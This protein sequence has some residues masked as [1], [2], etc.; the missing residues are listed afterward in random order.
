MTLY[1]SPRHVPAKIPSYMSIPWFLY[2]S[3]KI[4]YNR[5]AVLL[6]NESS[7]ACSPNHLHKLFTNGTIDLLQAVRIDNHEYSQV[8]PS[9]CS[10]G[11][12]NETGN[13]GGPFEIARTAESDESKGSFSV[14]RGINLR[15]D[16]EQIFPGM[17]IVLLSAKPSF[18]SV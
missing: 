17:C 16:T 9:Q 13:I 3:N 8:Q 7:L 10:F 11:R 4:H 1:N 6:W 5:L 12:K 15:I 18:P 2:L 14:P